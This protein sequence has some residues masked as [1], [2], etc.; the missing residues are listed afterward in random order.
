M[1]TLLDSCQNYQQCKHCCNLLMIPT[2]TLSALDTN[3]A[4]GLRELIRHSR[5][6]GADANNMGSTEG[7][8]PRCDLRLAYA[9]HVLAHHTSDMLM[10]VRAHCS[11]CS[12]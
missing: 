8:G 3:I 5:C 12:R 4:A 7:H 11:A 1:S 10:W 9:S 2:I 6:G